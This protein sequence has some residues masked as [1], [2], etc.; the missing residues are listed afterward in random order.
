MNPLTRRVS[1]LEQRFIPPGNERDRIA[2]KAIREARCRRLAVEGKEP[3]QLP[4]PDPNFR[5]QSIAEAIWHARARARQ[6]DEEKRSALAG[7]HGCAIPA[8]RRSNETS[9][10]CI[11]A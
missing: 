8:K 3:E 5:P 10:A 9:E 1:K 11:E 2:A 6:R 7:S 4:P